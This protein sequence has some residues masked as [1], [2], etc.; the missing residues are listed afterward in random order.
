MVGGAFSFPRRRVPEFCGMDTSARRGAA[1]L[2]LIAASLLLYWVTALLGSSVAAH[3]LPGGGALPPYSLDVG[4]SAWTV[5][6][7]LYAAAAAGAA[8]L[9]IAWRA[10]QAG[11]EP[12]V[13]PLLVGSAVAVLAL[14]LVPPTGSDDVYSYAAY[15][16][17][18]TTGHD[19][20]TTTADDLP[21][22]PVAQAVTP[23]WRDT[24]SVY[25]PVATGLHAAVMQFA[26][27]SVRWGVMGLVWLSAAAF[28]A[29]AALLDR[30][31][32]PEPAR[33]RAALLF[34]V[35]P[36]LI[37]QLVAGAHVDALVALT[38]VAA[39]LALHRRP[40]LAG[41]L[42]GTA[43]SVKLT[44]GLAAVGVAWHLRH[45]LRELWVVAGTAML[46][47]VP[48]YL[49]VGGTTALGQ[50]REA[51]R[52]VSH[53]TLWRPVAVQLDRLAGQATSRNVLTTLSLLLLGA[54]TA[55]LWRAGGLS[56]AAAPGAGA[57]A[58]LIV[59]PVVA[60]LLAA[61]YLLP[62]YTAPA[63]ALLALLAWS[64][65]DE[66]L[67]TATTMLTLAYLPGRSVPLPP[68]VAGVTRF[69]R[70]GAGPVVLAGL[71]AWAL[72]L[73]VRRGG[74]GSPSSSPTGATSA[75]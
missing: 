21:A 23:P 49:L 53:A 68:G 30:Y 54:L 75:R 72:V 42:L 26:G 58:Q 29:T 62:W 67:L 41:A 52:F 22:D 73:I 51:S 48:A 43:V 59:V 31:A 1:G 57:A 17:M 7:L 46:V 16:R 15:G 56:R 32:G 24:P 44:A 18:A 8:G 27:D 71:V 28:L 45:R 65:W 39:V 12:R 47:A 74:D 19:P 10:L 33:R 4:G 6:L 40:W 25:G 69:V 64:R 34:A 14:C 70:A 2:A 38:V 37:F 3:A 61:T 35:N 63:W 66:L 20:Y 5:T 55:L 9:L 60:W 36:L 50:A 11:W 13:R